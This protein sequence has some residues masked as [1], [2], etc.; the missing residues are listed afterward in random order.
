MMETLRDALD[1][2]GI[3]S[4]D[5]R[6]FIVILYDKNINETEMQVS[7]RYLECPAWKYILD[8]YVVDTHLM[9]DMYGNETIAFYV[10]DVDVE[11]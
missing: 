3:K 11:N 1:N 2:M 4:G 7:R 5:N 10:N 9:T 6:G 8:L